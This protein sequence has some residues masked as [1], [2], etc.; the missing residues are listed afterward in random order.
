M[1]DTDICKCN[2]KPPTRMVIHTGA[3]IELWE[4]GGLMHGCWTAGI[5]ERDPVFWQRVGNWLARG[6]EKDLRDL[7]TGKWALP[8]SPA[9]E[10]DRG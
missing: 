1:G 9:P 10:V 4:S 8:G 6:D 5:V 2:L 3:D 7:L